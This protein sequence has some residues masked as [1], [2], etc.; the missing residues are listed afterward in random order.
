MGNDHKPSHPDKQT[1]NE[2]K[3]PVDQANADD[4]PEFP[5][6]HTEQERERQPGTRTRD[7]I[8]KEIPR[9]KND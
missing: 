3:D 9:G 1:P 2:P 8:R 4:D 6:R 7:E 5:R